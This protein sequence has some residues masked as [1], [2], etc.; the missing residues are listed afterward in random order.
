MTRTY[1]EDPEE[2]KPKRIEP[3]KSL[4][5]DL[6]QL[7]EIQER[8]MEDDHKAPTSEEVKE[9]WKKW[10]QAVLHPIAD[11]FRLRLSGKHRRIRS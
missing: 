10:R 7:Y 11:A 9:F 3:D 6:H 4:L 5:T 1:S 2:L 8:F